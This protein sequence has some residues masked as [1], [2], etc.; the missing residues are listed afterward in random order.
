MPSLK[1]PEL[2]PDLARRLAAKLGL[3]FHEVVTKSRDNAPQKTMQNR[4]H[5]ATNLDGAFA[6]G[7]PLPTGPVLLVDDVVDSG[8]TMAIIAAQ[9]REAGSNLVYPTA[10]ASSSHT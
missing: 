2:V 5:Q 10:L 4:Y 8:W 7:T 6:I 3:E 1:H 9:L